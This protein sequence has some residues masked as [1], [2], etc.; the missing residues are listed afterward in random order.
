MIRMILKNLIGTKVHFP[1]GLNFHHAVSSNFKGGDRVPLTGIYKEL[2]E[3]KETVAMLNCIQ[4]ERF[5]ANEQHNYG[6]A[7]IRAAIK[8]RLNK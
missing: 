4:G 7:F 3:K 8:H 1:H 2:N 6:Y 5:P